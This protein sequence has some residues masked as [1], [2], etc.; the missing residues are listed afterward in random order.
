MMAKK[1]IPKIITANDLINGDVIYFTKSND[2]SL[3]HD[4]AMPCLNQ[5]EADE[6]LAKA[7]L[8]QSKIVGA[9][10][11]DIG[12]DKNQKPIP[13]HFREKF[14]AKGPSNYPHGKQETSHTQA[15][16]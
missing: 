2:W 11:A 12:F 14:R 15:V 4:E 1:Y 10:L 6:I 5:N 7:Q 13:L 9:Y 8:H 16:E 3:K